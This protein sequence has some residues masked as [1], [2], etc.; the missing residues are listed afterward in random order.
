MKDNR[1][2]FTAIG[3]W[4]ILTGMVCNSHAQ[5]TLQNTYNQTVNRAGMMLTSDNKLNVGG[6]GQIDFNMPFG[7]ETLYNG[8]LDVHRLVLLFGYRFNDKLSFVTE[9]EVEHVKEI[10]V[11]QAFIDYSF[12]T[13]FSLRGGLVLIPMGII[14]EY[15]EPTTFNGVERPLIDKYISPTTWR[16][17]GFGATG[18]IP[19]VSMRYQAYIV[20]GLKSYDDGVAYLNGKNGLRGGRQKGAEAIFNF[21]NFAGR[22]EYYGML[23]LNLGLSGYFGKT[24]STLFND[25]PKNDTYAFD[26]ADSSIV[27][28]SM[29]G[30]DVRYKRKGFGFRGQMYYCNIDN[31]GQYN[32]FTAVDGIP[33]NLGESM[34]GYYVEVAYNV[35]RPITKIKSQLIPF[36]RFSNYDTEASM[37][38]DQFR[39][40]AFNTTVI[41]TGLGYWIVSQVAVKT[42][43]QFIKSK[44]SEN[45]SK[46]FNA[47]IA[48]TF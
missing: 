12:N 30:F 5:S 21:P 27:G 13:Y 36:V 33:N 11:E 6:Y 14:N 43:F 9:I 28:V 37:A 22:V 24:Q 1:I 26:Q 17:I 16:D 45:F 29:I 25:I 10:Y 44:G 32:E 31:S 2:K 38:D 41:T 35:F 8:T 23:G 7:G 40:E 18:T 42:D 4:V 48:V 15:H 34:Y 47:G 19:E 20:N 46:T 3:L 39:N